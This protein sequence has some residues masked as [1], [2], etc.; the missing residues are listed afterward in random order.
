MTNLYPFHG[1]LNMDAQRCDAPPFHKLLSRQMLVRTDKWWNIQLRTHPVQK[2]ID[3]EAFVSHDA[4]SF[5][6]F[7]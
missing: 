2:V 4:V 3:G 1:T 7:L 5:L 6:E